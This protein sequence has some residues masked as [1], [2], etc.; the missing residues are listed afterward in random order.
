MGTRLTPTIGI[1]SLLGKANGAPLEENGSG[2][3]ILSPQQVAFT[4]RMSLQMAFRKREG[5]GT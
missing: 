5:F 4:Q 3:R 1:S 2:A